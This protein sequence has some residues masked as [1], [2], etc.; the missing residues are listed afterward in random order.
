MD[1]KN[2]MEQGNCR[3]KECKLQAPDEIVPVKQ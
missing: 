1:K 3:F 2:F